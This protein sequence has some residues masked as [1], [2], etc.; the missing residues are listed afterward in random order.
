MKLRLQV[1][2]DFQVKLKLKIKQFSKT[3]TSPFH[4]PH[5]PYKQFLCIG[6]VRCANT[7]YADFIAQFQN[8]VRKLTAASSRTSNQNA[9]K[10]MDFLRSAEV[11]KKKEKDSATR[12]PILEELKLLNSKG[13]NHWKSRVPNNWSS[14]AVDPVKRRMGRNAGNPLLEQHTV[15]NGSI[16][17]VLKSRIGTELQKKLFLIHQNKCLC[18]R[19]SD[20]HNTSIYSV[21]ME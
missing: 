16:G 5:R 21:N 6:A 7:S 19:V 15:V 10:G 3:Y 12:K 17:I 2:L 1:K 18:A 4:N 8:S 13:L 20:D 9:K 11:A 14:R